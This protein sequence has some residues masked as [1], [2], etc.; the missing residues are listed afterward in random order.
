MISFSK[1]VTSLILLLMIIMVQISLAESISFNDKSKWRLSGGKGGWKVDSESGDECITVTGSGES[2]DANHWKYEYKLEPGQIYKLTC[3]IKTSTGAEGSNILMGSNL[4]NRDVWVKDTWELQTLIFR[5]PD[6][7]DYSY[8]RFGQ[9]R[10]TGTIWF[11]DIKLTKVEPI[12]STTNTIELGSGE[13]VSGRTYRASYNFQGIESTYSRCLEKYNA[14]FNTNRFTLG[15][16]DYIIFKHV[17]GD[18]RMKIQRGGELTINIGH[19]TRGNCLVEV[20]ADGNSWRRTGIMNSKGEKTFRIDGNFYPTNQIFVRLSASG[21]AA[22]FQVYSYSYESQLAIEMPDV[23]GSTDYIAIS[24]RQKDVAVKLES[25]GEEDSDKPAVIHVSNTSNKEQTYEIEYNVKGS[26]Q[27]R[28]VTVPPGKSKKV[29]IPPESGAELGAQRKLVV[30]KQGSSEIA[31]EAEANLK[32]PYMQRANYGRLIGTYKNVTLWYTD[33]TRKI[34]RTRPAPKPPVAKE[35]K[36]SAA[37][38]EY[39]PVQLVIR[40]DKDLKNVTVEKSIFKSKNGDVI[41]PKYF[42][43]FMVDYVPIEHPTDAFGTI[44][45]WPDPLPPVDKPFNVSKNSNQPLW[46]LVYVPPTTKAGDYYADIHLSTSEWEQ[47]VPI[48]LEVW[49]FTLPK[50]NHLKSSFGFQ[51]GYVRDY[52]NYTNRNNIGPLLEKYFK[53]FAQHRISPYNP[54]G[55]YEIDEKFDAIRLN[56]KLDMSKFDLGIKKYFGEYGFT[57]YRTKI[58]GLGSGTFHNRNYGNIAGFKQGTA[59]YEKLMTNYLGQLQKSFEERNILDKAYVYWFDEPDR[60]DYDFVIETNKLLKKAAPKIQK[61]LTEQPESE[62]YGYVDIWCPLI[63]NYNHKIANERRKLGEKFWWYICTVPKEPYPTLFIDHNAVELRVWIWM[64]WKYN[65]DGILIWQSNYWTS[66]AAY[67]PPKQQN[68]Y[69]DPM[70]YKSGYGLEGGDIVHWGN[71][72]GRFLYPPK[73]VFESN[74]PCH[75]GPVSSIRW[76]MLREGMEDYEYLWMLRDLIKRVPKNKEILPLLNSANALLKVP[77]N[78]A[79]STT[80][81]TSTPDPIYSHRLKIAKMILR[82]QK[83]L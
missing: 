75:E 61:L 77:E 43:I 78:I 11:K 12:H 37:I 30:K 52:H 33:G 56:A 65:M 66:N 72:D 13:L 34:G 71:G 80:E 22:A 4:V 17:L 9:W 10:V 40:P 32:T 8:L 2:N 70:S 69:N 64:S 23:V 49:D 76:E 58:A 28:F 35:I 59:K 47:K 63:T 20:S 39:E 3:M 83:E 19:Y 5:T 15:A 57:T 73:A 45:L 21:L 50:K 42:E 62:L 1:K 6:V 82:L 81:F 38:N 60:R 41:A 51:P 24:Q 16:K 29:S 36:L 67:P 53:S 27:R 25:L 74:A 26:I 79:K 68:P 54:F 48:H 31:Y 18:G 55:M 7:I 44:G 14:T 46:L